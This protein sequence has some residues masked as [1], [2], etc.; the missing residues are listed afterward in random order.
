M[1][2]ATHN[3]HSTHNTSNTQGK[4]NTHNVRDTH[5]TEADIVVG[6]DG[7]QESFCALRW[8]L[9]QSSFT[10]Q[11][12]NA[13]YGWTHSWNV[14]SEPQNEEAWHA[15]QQTITQ[16]LEAWAQQALDG[17][18]FNVSKLTLTSVHASGTA[19]LLNIG[20]NA[21]QI[22]VGRRSL[23][24]VARWLVGSLS[25][26][27]VQ[28]ATVP[29]T[30]VRA[31]DEERS[32]QD[33]IAHML[34]PNVAK[35]IPRPQ[36]EEL[37]IVV[38]V[39]G[40]EQSKHALQFAIEL[41]QSRSSSLRVMYCWQQK[42]LHELSD[43]SNTAPLATNFS[44]ANGQQQAQEII[45]NIVAQAQIPQDLECIAQAFHIPAAKGLLS[46]SRLARHVVVGS[47]GLRGLDARLL[48]SVSRQLISLCEC[49]LTVV[50]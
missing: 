9:T 22:V 16:Q 42:D 21:Q 37:P 26:N 14:G 48:G 28:E 10:G 49:S 50:R 31:S 34:A 2:Y 30:I 24:R 44:Q 29:V 27:L 41:A 20:K 12:V 15:A 5:N 46:A 40:S 18:D 32:V 38:G 33:D 1:T 19:A 45:D 23:N 35:S 13:V 3:M 39:D 7:S 25:E 4:H 17:I 47:R 6:V 43:A 36:K 8:A 11:N